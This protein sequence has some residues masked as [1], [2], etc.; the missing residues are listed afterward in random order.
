MQ[1][2]KS[3][4]TKNKVSVILVRPAEEDQEIT[5]PKGATVE[6]ALEELG[7]S[8]PSGQSLYVGDKEVDMDDTLE[9]G[10]I[11]QVVG[12]KQGGADEGDEPIEG[13]EKEKKEGTDEEGAE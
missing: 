5:L 12:K 7:F 4:S 3:R 11:M 8:I 1:K 6:E 9:D 10:D 13:E 2:A